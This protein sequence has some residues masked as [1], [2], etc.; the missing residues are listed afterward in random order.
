MKYEGKILLNVI[1]LAMKDRSL[2]VCVQCVITLM[3]SIVKSFIFSTG[4]I[5]TYFDA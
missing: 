3:N 5:H 2:C 1:A 4:T